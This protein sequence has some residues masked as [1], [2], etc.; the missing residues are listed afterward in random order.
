MVMY[1]HPVIGGNS[2]VTISSPSPMNDDASM[3]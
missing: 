3:Q 1:G 2:P